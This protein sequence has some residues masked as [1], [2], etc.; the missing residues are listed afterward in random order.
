[1]GMK[2]TIAQRNGQGHREDS[3]AVGVPMSPDGAGRR[4]A[5]DGTGRRRLGELLLAEGVVTPD[6]LNRALE[7][8][9]AT[10]E[11]L[12]QVLLD[13]GV[14]DQERL[15]RHLGR[16][17]G[18]E[19]VRLVGTNLRED[20][21]TLLPQQLASRLQAIP[22]ARARG[23]L[24]VAM[25]DPLDVVA[26]DD[27]RRTTGLSIKVAL[28]TVQDFQYALGQDPTL[29]VAEERVRDLPEPQAVDEEMSLER[30]RR[31]AEDAPVIRLVNR[32]VEEAVRTRASDIHVE[33]QERHVRLRYRVDGVLLTRGTLPAHAHAQVISRIKIMANM[34][35]AERRLPQDGSFQTRV[36]GRAIDVRV[37][38]IPSFYGEKAVLRLLDKSAP[39]YDL[40]KLGLSAQNY[41]VLRRIIQRP[42]GIFLLTGPTGSGQTTTLYAILNQ[43]NNEKANVLTVEAPVEYQIAGITQMQVNV[44]A[45]VTFASSPRHF[46]RQ[47]PDIIMGAAER[48]VRVLCAKC[49]EADTAGAEELRARFGT[50]A[51][52]GTYYLGRGCEFCNY[53]GYRVRVAIF[54][55]GEMND[56]L[57][58][59]VINRVPHHALK[60]AAVA[61]GMTTL[62][63]D[64]LKK[65]AAGV[66]SLAEVWRV[67]SVERANGNGAEGS[68]SE[69]EP[70]LSPE[71]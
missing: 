67:V 5:P 65:A 59:L 9:R 12:G 64:G 3:P 47:A 15:A 51:P 1:M 36:D 53:T 62:L 55:I 52:A 11:R 43:L 6:Q 31:M 28:T 38:T 58:H 2:K 26:I 35:I 7:I 45:G 33:R 23:L 30:L 24:T 19:F 32:L 49:R 40:D 66:T 14:V 69:I 17:I 68:G 42:Q 44:R 57:R 25:V 70:R 56:E 4:P 61:A 54:E 34:D 16:Q 27:I 41:Q 8:H 13:M 21:L 60:E 18:A 39:I 37:S 10:G 46:L 20:V 22:I 71:H 29:D 63:E 50:A 48:L